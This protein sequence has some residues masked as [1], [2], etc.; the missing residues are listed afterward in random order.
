[1]WSSWGLWSSMRT[2]LV[3]LIVSNRLY[4]FIGFPSFDFGLCDPLQFV[5]HRIASYAVARQ[6][7]MILSWQACRPSVRLGPTLGG[8]GPCLGH[9]S[10]GGSSRSSSRRPWWESGGGSSTAKLAGPGL[11]LEG[12]CYL[13][14][15]ARMF[16]CCSISILLVSVIQSQQKRINC[17]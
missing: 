5:K 6:S 2:S 9:S 8:G 16:I 3:A 14:S 15:L 13:F 10:V 12:S 4:G 17:K 1:M 7:R 11:W